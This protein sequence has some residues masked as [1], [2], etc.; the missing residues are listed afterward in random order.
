MFRAQRSM[1]GWLLA[2]GAVMGVAGHAHGQFGRGPARPEARGMLKSVDAS[3]GTVTVSMFEPR[4]E[5]REAIEKTYTLAKDAEVV[6]AIGGGGGR[7]G[8]G[9]FK[10]AKLA[11][12]PS[13]PSVALTLSADQTAVEAIVAEGTMVHGQ[14]KAVDA[15]KKT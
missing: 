15:A 4:K 10:E 9:A 14:P 5:T 6:V 8:G 12:L 7:R 11:D 13:G 2:A 1:A 3:A